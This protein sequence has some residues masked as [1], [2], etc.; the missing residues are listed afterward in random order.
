MSTVYFANTS[1]K[2]KKSLLEKVEILAENAG[3]KN[4]I[5][6]DELV[7]VK[8]H[9]GERGNTGFVSP[10]FVR[11]VVG[12]IKEAGGRPFVTD[13]NTLYK[14]SR[15]NAVS[16]IETAL[17]NGFSYTTVEAPIIISDGL[18]GHD[19]QEIKVN[20]KHHKSVKIS[21]AAASAD[22]LVV[23][24]HFKGHEMAGFGGALKNIGMGLGSPGAK[25]VMHSDAKPKVNLEACTACKRCVKWC[26]KDA[27]TISER[28]EID[29]SKCYSCGECT[30]SCISNAISIEWGGDPNATT[31][32]IVEHA[33]GT[34]KGK[35]EK[36]LFFNFLMNITPDCDCWGWSDSYI[37]SDIGVLASTD[38]VAIDTASLDMVNKAAGKDIFKE[39]SPAV[40]DN[41]AQLKYAQEMGI[42]SMK[43][44]LKK[45]NI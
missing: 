23:I 35:Q 14:G 21:S 38:P 31:E 25:Q 2:N 19:Y 42:G 29:P 36:S 22:A 39:I 37:I 40:P 4:I 26:P 45:L 28:A 7:A 20:G 8:V 11:R 44:E 10:I 27:I 9:F 6:K 41:R 18:N 13:A 1:A 32:R 24:S 15:G 17:Q 5:E 34:M 30:V 33:A 16:H 12:K 43:Y 3:I